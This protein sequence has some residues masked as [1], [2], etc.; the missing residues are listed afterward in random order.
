VFDLAGKFQVNLDLLDRAHVKIQ[1]VEIPLNTGWQ[2]NTST[3]LELIG[4]A[5]VTWR[6]P[7]STQID[8]Q[9]PCEIIIPG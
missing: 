1:G 5:C 6:N 4:E 7:A 2:M 8:L 3:Q 9:F